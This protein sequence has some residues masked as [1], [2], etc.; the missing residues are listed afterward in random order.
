MAVS[1]SITILIGNLGQDPEIRYTQSNTPVANLSVATTDSWKDKDGEWQ[2]KTEWHR[3]VVFGYLAEKA[4]KLRKGQQVYVL[5]KNETRKWEK[6]GQYHYTTEV[7]AKS[8]YAL[9]RKGEGRPAGVDDTGHFNPPPMP[10]E[11][12]HPA[13]SPGAKEADW[14]DDDLP[15]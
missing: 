11:E 1:E 4:E 8:L 13:A 10:E 15:F 12:R 9:G 7:K 6:D 2:E 14:D 5:G 3:V